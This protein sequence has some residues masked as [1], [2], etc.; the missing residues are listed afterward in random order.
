[1]YTVILNTKPTVSAMLYPDESD[2]T[3]NKAE[4][5]IQNL[6]CIEH[7]EI[8]D[9][10]IIIVYLALSLNGALR[11][12]FNISNALMQD[13]VTVQIRQGGKV[14]LQTRCGLNL[15]MNENA[16]LE[17]FLLPDEYPLKEEGI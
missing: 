8:C 4:A 16:E 10:N 15:P 9:S 6:M 11:N 1:M 17:D 7:Y 3:H 13:F 14:V 2:Y 12:A 5:C